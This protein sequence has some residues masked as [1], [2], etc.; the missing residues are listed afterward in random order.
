MR[1]LIFGDIPGIPQLL[2][3][4]PAEHLIGIVGA[5]IRPQ[6]HTALA[7]IAESH[8]LP[9]LIQPRVD[10]VDYA[11]FG[12]AVTQLEPD[13]IWVNSYSM[14]LR[15]DVVRAARLGGINIHGALLPK[16]R[17]CNPTQWAILNGETATGVTMHEMS[18]GLDEGDIIDQS[19]VPLFFEDTWKTAYARISKATDALISANLHKILTAS[20]QVKQQDISQAN[21]YRRRTSE[22]G[23]FDWSHAVVDIYNKIRALLPP[24]PPAFYLDASGDK[25]PMDRQL[26]PFDITALKYGL[27]GRKVLESDCVQLCPLRREDSALLQDWI[28]NRELTILN[29]PFPPVSEAGHEAWIESVLSKRM[30]LVIFVIK[31]SVTAQAIGTCQLFNINWRHRSAEL[32]IRISNESS[33]NQGAASEVVKLLCNF[34]FTDLNLHRIYLH[35]FAND[36][37]A[38]DVYK[39]C[40]FIWEGLLTHAVYISEMWVDAVVMGKLNRYE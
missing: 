27:A 39:K 25:V 3:H 18:V 12:T 26:T 5:S 35:A 16:Y 36:I 8:K 29:M 32:Q 2:R 7:T 20:W 31:E 30:D 11:D 28:T 33:V 21:Y 17:G 19:V 34:G 23:L 14:I 9:F 38:I 4:I 1:I 24:L 40:G 10:S 6:Y 13:L 15:P 37:G 22:D